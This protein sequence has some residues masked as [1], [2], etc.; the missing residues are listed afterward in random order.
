[1]KK[2]L[3]VTHVSGFVPQFEMNNVR[4]LQEMGYEVHYASNFHNVSYGTDNHRLDGTGIVRHQVDFARSPFEFKNNRRALRQLK[5]VMREQHYDVVH[6]HTPVGA[7]YARLA[8][9]EHRKKRT[10]VIYTAHGF[11]FY[12]GAPLKFWL[13]SYP[14]EWLLAHVTDTL[15]TINEEDFQNAKKFRL[16]KRNGR[17]GQVYKINSVGIDLKKYKSD[18]LYMRQKI[19]QELEIPMEAFVLVSVG[20]LNWNKNHAV[21]LEAL[22][23]WKES[24]IYYIIC[25]EGIEKES[26]KQ[27][28]ERLGI[29]KQLCL[30]GFREDIP[31]I[32]KAADAMAFPSLREGL[33]MVAVEA[34][35]SGLPVVASDNRGTREYMQDGSNGYVVWNNAAED[36]AV[37]IQK[38]YWVWCED[39][40]GYAKMQQQ[41]LKTAEHFSSDIVNQTMR[42]IYSEE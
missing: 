25:G 14:M 29:G 38:L 8:A 40:A 35:A 41:A 12:K 37:A 24:S 2:A 30:T 11:H 15:I 31:E 32:L 23:R 17:P 13:V 16:G 9:R 42:A 28:A 5:Q 21:V 1:M 19:R 6:C 39:K 26:L 18:K 10:R 34:L 4:I 7:T 20:E 33:G 3:I 36:M 27:Q 22:G